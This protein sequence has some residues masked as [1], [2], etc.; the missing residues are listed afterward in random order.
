M[1]TDSMKF[2]LGDEI[3]ALRD[4]VHRFA[5]AEI[6]PRAAEIDRLNQF[7]PDLWPKLGALGILGVT[8]DPAYGGAGMG[9]LAHAV[10]MEEVSPRV[11][12]G[13]PLLRRAFEPVRQPDQ[14]P[15]HAGAEGALSAQADLRRARR[16]ARDVGAGRRLRRR[17]DE[18]ARREAQ[19]PLCAERHQDVDHQRPRRRHAGRLRPDRS[20]RRLARH[21]RVPGREDRSRVSRP[22]PSSTSW[23]CAAPTPPS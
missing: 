16:R 8:A 14:P 22:A 19:R 2:G 18:I 3:E 7:P 23:A 21:H 17:V 10:A 9:Y 5:Q 4:T 1:F 11:R 13:R 20:G 15:R 12:L 6:A